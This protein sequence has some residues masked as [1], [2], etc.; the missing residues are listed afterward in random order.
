MVEESIPVHFT[1]PN[2][3]WN[4]G[5]GSTWGD[6]VLDE[7]PK[8]HRERFKKAHLEEVKRH[9]SRDG[10]R[11]ATPVVFAIAKKGT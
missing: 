7:M 5:R 6:L 10:V 1:A 4:Y 11:T 3:W 9:F 8:E 2:D